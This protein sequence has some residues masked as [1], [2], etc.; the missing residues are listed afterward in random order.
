MTRMLKRLAMV[1]A[2]ALFWAAQAGAVGVD[3]GVKE[4]TGSDSYNG[5]SAFGQVNVDDISLEPM[6]NSFHS[7][8]SQGTFNT[9]SMRLGYD[10]KLFGIGLTGGTTPS[11][12]G[13]NNK[14]AGVDATVSLSPTGE[15][16]RQRI[17]GREQAA[18][19]AEGQGLARVDL[20]AAATYIYHTDHQGNLGQDL[21]SAAHMGQADITGSAG[22]AILESLFSVDVTKSLYEHKPGGFDMLAPRVENIV[23]LANVVQG[24]PNTSVN[25][26]V[27]FGTPIIIPTPLVKPFLQY[28]HTTFEAGEANSNAYSAGLDVELGI[29]EVAAAYERYV[30]VGTADHNFVSVGANVRF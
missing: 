12:N 29:L 23:G 19:P 21:T 1:S 8:S 14:F 16:A 15:G 6:Y 24:Y 18:G 11:V 4:I 20:G 30:Q 13:Y 3:A 22:I 2:A 17:N 28:T 7:N 9:Y 5:V 25:A 27:L 26:K 10:T